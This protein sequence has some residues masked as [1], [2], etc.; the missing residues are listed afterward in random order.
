MR[1]TDRTILRLADP[2]ERAALFTP[3]VGAALLAAAYVFDEVAV[4]EVTAVTVRS[5]AL[6]PVVHPLRQMA[7]TA[8]EIMSGVQW[9]VAADLPPAPTPAGHA[10]VEVDV[11]ASVRGVVSDVVDVAS[12]E[13]SSLADLDVID[14]LVVAADGALPTDPEVLARRRYEELVGAI[15]ARFTHTDP[16]DVEAALH[17]RGMTT[18]DP[19]RAYLSAP[20]AVQRLALTVVTD[21]TAP[22]ADRS[23]RLKA[24][25]HVAEDV[26]TELTSALA[27]I[28]LARAALRAGT[29][30]PA[31]PTGMS[32]RL[33]HP[34]VLVVP[35]SG[36]DDTDLP[37]PAGPPPTESDA[38]RAARLAELTTRLRTA[39]VV[40]V[41]V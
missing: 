26:T 38:L 18:L 2:T 23:Y 39:A 5:V 6:A 32:A 14:A 10:V 17:R 22:A 20:N 4:G 31:V 24:L 36:L 12:T 21:S 11:T 8:R 30:P 35:R 1:F 9:Q 37:L 40:P 28:A 13:L 41:A 3:A 25:V 16:A 19:L 33:D 15:A 7:A 27:A 29:D 34:A